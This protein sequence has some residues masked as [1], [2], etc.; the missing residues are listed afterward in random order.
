VFAG[1]L[2]AIA[3]EVDA[4]NRHFAIEIRTANPGTLLSGMYGVAT[5]PLERAANAVT[6]PREA[7]ASRGGKSVVLRVTGGA[8]EEVAITEGIGNGTHVAVA[9]GLRAGDVILADARRELA[10]GTAVN[11]V[12]A[13]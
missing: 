4:K 3:P 9:S 1:R 2:A 5:I 11:A 6:V 13:R 12:L 10:P 8:I 7:V